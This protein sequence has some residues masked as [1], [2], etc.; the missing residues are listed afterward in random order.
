MLYD[1]IDDQPLVAFEWTAE[2]AY[3]V[4]TFLEGLAEAVWCRHGLSIRA[5]LYPPRGYLD[6]P[7]QLDLPFHPKWLGGDDLPF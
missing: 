7:L 4:V 3:A 1:D 5:L 6:D 2:E